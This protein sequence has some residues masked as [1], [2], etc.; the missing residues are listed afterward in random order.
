MHY[1]FRT[2]AL[3]S[4]CLYVRGDNMGFIDLE[5][6]SKKYNS[7]Y[8]L[9]NINLSFNLGEIVAILGHSGSGKTTLLQIIG[10]QE[11]GDG[12]IL[13]D[14][15]K[16]NKAI[17]QV[18]LANL[19]AYIYQDFQLIDYFNAEQNINLPFAKEKADKKD[20]EEICSK[21]NISS[22]L[23]SY[24]YELSGG[25][26]Q[27][28]AIARALIKKPKVIL[29]DEPTGCLDSQTSDEIMDILKEN[30]EGKLIIIATHNEELAKKYAT[31]IIRLNEGE[32]VSDETL[33]EN[34]QIVRAPINTRLYSLSI[35]EAFKETLLSYKKRKKGIIGVALIFAI[36]LTGIL[37]IFGL[38]EGVDTYISYLNNTRLDA[39]Y[40][41]LSYYESGDSKP[42]DTN[43]LTSLSNQ[44]ISYFS[45]TNF[46]Y[47][48]NNFLYNSLEQDEPLDFAYSY[49]FIDFDL[50]SEHQFELLGLTIA[51][52]KE[53]V[54]INSIFA[55][56]LKTFDSI[57]LVFDDYVLERYLSLDY[58]LPIAG[59]IDEG[60]LYNEAKIYF[61]IRYAYNIFGN[62]FCDYFFNTQQDLNIPFYLII[63]SDFE[64]AYDYLTSRDDI[65]TIFDSSSNMDSYYIFNNSSLILRIAFASL[66]KAFKTIITMSLLLILLCCFSLLNL[67]IA[68]IIKSR[69]KELNLRKSFGA[70]DRDLF[71]IAFSEAF[72]I[73][74][75]GLFI[76]LGL[77]LILH[78]VIYSTS[79]TLLN[80][81][82]SFDLYRISIAGI[83]SAFFICLLTSFFAASKP[84]NH[85]KKEGLGGVIKN[86]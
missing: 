26:Q 66:I 18:C 29:A 79:S 81:S 64:A 2:F 35:K 53:K 11:E 1:F 12:E 47:L 20:L 48:A 15:R 22:K 33:I 56:H 61:D 4:P 45:H 31:R 8:A 3:F 25:E 75:S 67:A 19:F 14:G 17:K 39:K 86:E 73:T 16:V 41:E 49:A 60:S 59:T 80:Q 63:F 13:I 34:Q 40:V 82:W 78:F 36:C 28:V 58:T 72:I 76:A 46:N 50:L 85:L 9:K 7:L 69:T 71:F 43:V 10:L 24:P 44:N 6:I 23:S 62:D 70:F 27:R 68:F 74:A 83:I 54:I 65:F 55:K 21:L 52:S 77:A 5:G 38:S 57:D 30:A 84:I 42:F 37:S 32:V 51:P